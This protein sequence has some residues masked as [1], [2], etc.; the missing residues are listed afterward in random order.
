[1]IAKFKISKVIEIKEECVYIFLGNSYKIVGRSL[2]EARDNN[3]LEGNH[4]AVSTQF[5]KSN[6]LE[7]KSWHHES[8]GTKFLGTENME[9]IDR[10]H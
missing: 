2:F 10:N 6:C 5:G 9:A 3:C 7:A 4:R 1:M 8:M